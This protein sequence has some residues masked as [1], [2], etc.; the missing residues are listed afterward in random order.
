MGLLYN[1]ADKKMRIKRLPNRHLYEKEAKVLDAQAA[2]SEA[3]ASFLHVCL[4]TSM[5]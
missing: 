3:G 2:A 1:E 5:A 4:P